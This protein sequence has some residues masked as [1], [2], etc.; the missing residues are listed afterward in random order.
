MDERASSRTLLIGLIVSLVLHATV[1]LPWLIEAM[2]RTS[3]GSGRL[4]AHFEPEH[5]R[6][7]PPDESVRLGIEESTASTTTWIGYDEYQ[8]HMAALAET[9]QAAFTTNPPVTLPSPA[10]PPSEPTEAQAAASEKATDP[11]AE[12]EAWLEAARPGP[13]P[14]EGEPTAPN[15]RRK[16]LDDAL[17]RLEKML[18]EPGR[19][20]APAPTTE[21]EPQVGDPTDREADATSTVKVPLNNIRLGKPLAAGG[22]QI[23]TRKPVFT[24]LTLMTAAPANPVAELRFR[25]DGK[26]ATVRLLEGSGDS[27]IDEAI[28]NSL[29]RWRASGKQLQELEDGETLPVRIQIVLR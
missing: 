3:F 12:M 21:T 1:L 15:A 23:K 13:G 16:T 8:E 25:R 24:I 2:R 6:E 19:P 18:A 11:L 5:F 26:P 10:A 29:Y 17:A 9:E 14:V 4:L 28:L 20:T 22:L 27:R 7:P